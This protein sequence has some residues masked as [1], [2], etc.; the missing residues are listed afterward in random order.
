MSR[1]S[2]WINVTESCVV[3]DSGWPCVSVDWHQDNDTAGQMKLFLLRISQTND[4]KW[5]VV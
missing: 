2:Q 3:M 5:A 1:Q 4:N